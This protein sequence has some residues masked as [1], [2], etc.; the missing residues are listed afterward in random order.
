M[1]KKIITVDENVFLMKT[2]VDR[3]TFD[4]EDDFL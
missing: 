1:F 4:K 2:Q 3:M